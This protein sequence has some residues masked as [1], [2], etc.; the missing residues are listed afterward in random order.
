MDVSKKLHVQALHATSLLRM[1]SLI[2]AFLIFTTVAYAQQKIISGHIVVEFNEPLPGATVALKNSSS[3]TITNDK[4]DYSINAS[5]GDVLVVSFVG[6]QTLESKV[7]ESNTIDFTMKST[8]SDLN[9]VVVVAYGTA[10]KKDLT[11]SVATVSEKDFQKGQISTID[12]LFTGKVAGVQ[13]TPG[14]GAPGSSGRI[15]I[16]GGSS[17]NASNSPLIVIDGVPIDNID[18]SIDRDTINNN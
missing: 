5:V 7:G 4:G 3:G 11:G 10:R 6:N 8:S 18:N 2:T 17:L 9:Q 16:R 14:N 1:C 13:I 12:Q 15:R